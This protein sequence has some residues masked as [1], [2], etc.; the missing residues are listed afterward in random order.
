MKVKIINNDDTRLWRYNSVDD[1]DGLVAF[2]STNWGLTSFLAQYEDDEG[3][4][5]TIASGK[6]LRDAQLAKEENRKSLKVF[7]QSIDS[8][9]PEQKPDDAVSGLNVASNIDADVDEKDAPMKDMKSMLVDFVNNDAVMALVPELFA[10]IVAQIKER[11][12]GLNENEIATL[13]RSALDN[14]ETYGVISQHPLCINY[15]ALV[16]PYIAK[17]C[18]IS[19]RCTHIS[20][21][22]RL[23]RGSRI[24]CD[25]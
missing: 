19:S 23:N 17:K 15:I 4:L 3:D 6:D 21:V 2:I 8:K 25:C 20:R 14:T 22:I 18:S 9:K 13:I 1:F 12:C 5:I 16:L 10:D 7:V 11:N 24:C